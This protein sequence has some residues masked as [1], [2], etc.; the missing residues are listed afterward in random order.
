[1]TGTTDWTVAVAQMDCVL[2]DRD[3]N[4]ERIAAW[5]DAARAA[6]ASL[7]VLPECATTGYF[8]ADRLE[9]LAEPVDGPS[10]RRLGA[11]A[12]HAGLHMAVGMVTRDGPLFHDSQLLFGPS[13]DLLAAY[14]K[15]HLF[16]SERD[17]YT[18]GDGPVVV[19]TA[20][21]RIGLSVCYDLVFADYIRTL[22]ELGADLVVNST[23]WIHDSWQRETW[24]FDGAVTRA[25]A[26]TRALEN[27]TF[28]A[29]ASRAGH[30]AGFT[31]FGH[32]CVAG[33][34]GRLLAA[35]GAGPGLATAPIST[36]GADL[37]RWRS[38][39]S[40]RTDRRP[41]LYRA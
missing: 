8:I 39:A 6:G 22:V 16:S 19:D 12:R 4:L 18:P 33:P 23:N 9:E 28:V 25:L 41:D 13:G 36:A 34:S 20:L 30:E 27:T 3:A 29:M 38:I 21:G 10:A 1:M 26:G 32:S 2:G 17:Q 24:G 7:V 14:R 37:D 5:A 31:S 15:V 11:I 35:L 40:Y